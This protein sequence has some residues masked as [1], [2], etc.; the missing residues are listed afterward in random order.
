MCQGE[1]DEHDK[2]VSLLR[3]VDVVISTLPYPQVLAQFK[4]IDAM[5]VSGNI[6]VSVSF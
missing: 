4:I 5:K 3:Q 2:L 6:K 1:L